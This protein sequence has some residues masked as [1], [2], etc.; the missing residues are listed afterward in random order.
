MCTTKE[1]Y[2]KFLDNFNRKKPQKR[3]NQ[4]LKLYFL[5]HDNNCLLLTGIFIKEPYKIIELAGNFARDSKYGDVSLM[6]YLF[7]RPNSHVTYNGYVQHIEH[8]ENDNNQRS[9]KDRKDLSNFIS[10]QP[11]MTNKIISKLIFFGYPNA[12]RQ[13]ILGLALSAFYPL[14]WK[15]LL[16]KLYHS[17]IKNN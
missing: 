12:K 10:G 9:Y 14:I 7:S 2:S 1:G 3:I 13:L 6:C 16:M 4:I 5:S 8:A 17:K 15:H 11:G